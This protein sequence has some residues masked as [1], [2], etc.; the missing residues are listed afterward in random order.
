MVQPLFRE[1]YL[2]QNI[3]MIAEALPVENEVEVHPWD[4]VPAYAVT[5][6]QYRSF[7]R[8]GYLI[9]RGLVLPEHID[10]LRAHTEDLLDEKFDVTPWVH[11]KG[12]D[13]PETRLQMLHRIHM[14]HLSIPLWERYL[15]YPRCP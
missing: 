5:V 8:D 3:R 1:R 7:R 10:E 13:E 6:D 12:G 11:S 4:T 14:G 2:A 9:V 15:L